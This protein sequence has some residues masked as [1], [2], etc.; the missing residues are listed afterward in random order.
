M[1][2]EETNAVVYVTDTAEGD[3][4]YAACDAAGCT[5]VGP[6]R[7]TPAAAK[8]DAIRHHEAP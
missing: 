3:R 5:W 4:Y 7:E 2:F 1:R 8:R 6:T